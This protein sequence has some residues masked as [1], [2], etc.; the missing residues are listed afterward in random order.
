MKKIIYFLIMLITII[1]FTGCGGND[2]G[3]KHKITFADENANVIEVP[4]KRKFK[5]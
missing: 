1:S 4:E 5:K 2:D 3:T